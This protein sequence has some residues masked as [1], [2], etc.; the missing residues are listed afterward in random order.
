MKRQSIKTK[1]GQPTR[2]AAVRRPYLPTVSP[3]SEAH[4]GR[5]AFLLGNQPHGEPI[6][7]LAASLTTN[8][9]AP[10]VTT[11]HVTKGNADAA[12]K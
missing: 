10:M 4:D 2:G 1:S 3:Y 7:L 11:A 9:R 12:R 6:F 8:A 5:G